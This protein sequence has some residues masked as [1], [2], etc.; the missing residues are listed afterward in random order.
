MWFGHASL[1][2]NWRCVRTVPA[3]KRAKF[4]VCI[5]NRFEGSF[6]WVAMQWRHCH[7][8]VTYA[9]LC[10]HR[11][12]NRTTEWSKNTISARF[13]ILYLA[14]IIK[15][16]E[17]RLYMPRTLESGAPLTPL[18]ALPLAPL[19]SRRPE[20]VPSFASRSYA[21]DYGAG[22]LSAR[23]ASS[24][25]ACNIKHVGYFKNSSGCFDKHLSS[26][27]NVCLMYAWWALDERSQRSSLS[28][29][30]HRANAVSLVDVVGRINEVNQRMG[31]RHPGQ[32]SLA[33][34]QWICAM[35]EY[36]WKLRHK[37]L[38]FC[39]RFGVRHAYVFVIYISLIYDVSVRLRTYFF[40]K[41]W[42]QNV[43]GALEIFLSMRC[44]NLHFTLH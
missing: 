8:D 23:R 7:C 37:H 35:N 32:L 26:Q 10:T 16:W 14:E 33:I 24:I 12:T 27:L 9:P 39:V 3:N 17:L 43:F 1:S 6:V 22:W 41:Y 5:Y 44:I 29:Q 34:P 28:S 25:N 30:L 2:K 18:L 11:T 42:W 38:V 21:T 19:L 13:T 4:E 40:A 20:A 31:D 36:Q 15:N